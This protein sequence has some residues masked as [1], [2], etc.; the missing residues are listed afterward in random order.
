MGIVGIGVDIV[1]VARMA[2]ALDAGTTG[3]RF[4][5]RVFTAEERAY[6]EGRGAHAAESYAARF[7]AKEAVQ[8]ALGGPGKFGFAWPEIEIVRSP[9]GAPRVVLHGRVKARAETLGASAVHL[10]LAHA[11]QAAVAHAVVERS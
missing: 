1:D 8:K 10:S 11:A 4:K 9:S 6:C 3:E 5:R 7:A 2:R